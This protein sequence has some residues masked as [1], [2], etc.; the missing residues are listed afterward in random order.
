MIARPVPTA[1]TPPS[2][3]HTASYGPVARLGGG[4]RR[5]RPA[6]SSSRRARPRWVCCSSNGPVLLDSMRRSF[7]TSSWRAPDSSSSSS[8]SSSSCSG[9]SSS[10][11]GQ[12]AGD[13]PAVL[14]VGAGVAGLTAAVRWASQAAAGGVCGARAART[15]RPVQLAAAAHARATHTHARTQAAGCAAACARDRVRRGVWQRHHVARRRRRVDALQAVRDARG[16]GVQVC[17][18]V[19]WRALACVRA[20]VCVCRPHASGCR[21]RRTARALTPC[22]R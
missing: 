1:H 7:R 15:W 2:A 20:C 9:S 19:R 5:S 11:S 10:G 22:T 17:P 16:A 14:V 4:V 12:P 18:G 6:A 21:L 8:S 13:A 3:G